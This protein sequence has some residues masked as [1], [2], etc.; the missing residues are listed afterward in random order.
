MIKAINKFRVI[1]TNKQKRKIP[2]LV[3][4]TLV[5]TVL[6]IL[7]VSLVIP[8]V[9]AIV[10]ENIIINNKYASTICK[11][12][13]ITS[14]KSFIY[15]CIFLLVSVF[16]VK[17]AFLLFEHYYKTNYVINA[18]YET[19]IKLLTTILNRP[20]ESFLS[21]SSGELIRAVQTDVARTFDLF[22]TLISFTSE[23]IVSSAIIVLMFFVNPKMLLILSIMLLVIVYI[24]SKVIRPIMI[25]KGKNSR[26]HSVLTN[27][28]LLQSIRGVKEIKV[29]N[30]ENMFINN[31]SKSLKELA[32]AQKV[33]SVLNTVPK[34]LIEVGAVCAMLITIAIMI[35]SGSDVKVL[36]PTVSA[37]A[38]AALK[39]MPGANRIV[40]AS[41]ALA[42]NSPSVD[43][44]I[45]NLELFSEVK[46]E[47]RNSFSDIS[48]KKNIELKKITYAYPN[49]EEIILD[50]ASMKIPFGKTVGIVGKSGVGKTTAADIIMGLLQIKE[51]EILI[52][53]KNISDIY[54][55]WINKVG[56]IPQNIFVLDG[57]IKDNIVFGNDVFQGRLDE[58]LKEAQLF[59]FVKKLKDGIETKVGERGIRLSGGQKQRIGIARALYNNPDVLV[60]DEAT[61]SLDNETEAAVLESINSLHGKRTIVI[62]AHRPQTIETC[63]I[64][65]QIT[66]R[67]I[68]KI[69]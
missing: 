12:L 4:I 20:Y 5:G 26:Q 60:F 37:Y 16:I 54:Y 25:E 14:H 31:Y 48:F 29:T 52:D 17:N 11:V 19:Q 42:F 10:D 43:K 34:L 47:E 39:L 45:E 49:S 6:E 58:V 27:K 18:K 44:L 32:E 30:K 35:A 55:S 64:V 7:S 41:N 57:S 63:D 59:D 33:Y 65:Y 36:L 46:R 3:F 22:S 56:Y 8:L 62:I 67:K 9:S 50:K 38:M 61:S 40:H 1:L 15:L 13:N 69:R 23:M 21:N 53:G 2:F 51:G 66:D 68:K 24:L 28:W